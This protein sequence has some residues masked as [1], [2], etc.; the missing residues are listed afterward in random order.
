MLDQAAY[1]CA[2]RYASRYV[3]TMALD[4]VIFREPVH[5]GELVDFMASIN[6]TGGS[7]M[8]VGIKEVA[9]NIRSRQKR[10]V[11]SCFLTIVALDDQRQLVAV[12]PITPETP[13]ERRRHA[14]AAQRK[15]PRKEAQQR[16][17]A[18]KTPLEP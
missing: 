3:V 1:A 8:E 17:E 14:D 7:S 13:D 9:E 11:V 12:P 6:H 2:S 18:L 15:K 4:C 16:F 5:V 10:H